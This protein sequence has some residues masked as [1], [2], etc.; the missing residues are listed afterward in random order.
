M[1]SKVLKVGVTT[2]LRIAKYLKIVTNYCKL[3]KLLIFFLNNQAQNKRISASKRVAKFFLS[4]TSL[5]KNN[6]EGR[7]QKKLEN[8]CHLPYVNKFSA[9]CSAKSD[10]NMVV[11]LSLGRKGTK[12]LTS[13]S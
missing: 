4:V 3:E 12:L 1:L 9:K 10:W 6:Y 11:K 8:T 2:L 13:N 7:Q 5:K